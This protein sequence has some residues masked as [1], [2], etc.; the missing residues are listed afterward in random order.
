MGSPAPVQVLR[1]VA[2]AVDH[3]VAG[4]V[5]RHAVLQRIVEAPGDGRAAAKALAAHAHR[6][7]HVHLD[8]VHAAACDTR[9][10]ALDALCM[11]APSHKMS[12]GGTRQRPG[13]TCP[14]SPA[15]RP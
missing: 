4:E 1:V 3:V 2:H 7:L 15:S 10:S 5:G 11:H 14:P 8:A 6:A 9:Q 13:R 12:A